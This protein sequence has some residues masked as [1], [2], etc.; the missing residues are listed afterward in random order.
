MKISNQNRQH[1]L[2]ALQSNEYPL[3]RP[4]DGASGSAAGLYECAAC[5][6]VDRMTCTAVHMPALRFGH[7]AD[8][9]QAEAIRLMGGTPEMS[10][11]NLS[12]PFFTNTPG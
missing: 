3:F 12:A 4:D 10:N 11:R 5:G 9:P 1:V 6:G 2:D 8:C 7:H